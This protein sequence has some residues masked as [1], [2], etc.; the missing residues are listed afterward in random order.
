VPPVL[1]DADAI[2]RVPTNDI[3]HIDTAGDLWYIHAIDEDQF[4]F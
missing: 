1:P 3:I 2:Y 4:I